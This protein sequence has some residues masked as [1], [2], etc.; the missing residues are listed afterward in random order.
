MQTEL[1]KMMNGHVVDMLILVN[2]GQKQELPVPECS[3]LSYMVANG[4]YYIGMR[5]DVGKPR[6]S[7]IWQ[8]EGSEKK[9][10]TLKM[11]QFQVYDKTIETVRSITS[12]AMTCMQIPQSSFFKKGRICFVTDSEAIKQLD[13]L[14]EAAD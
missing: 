3:N 14:A 11:L 10:I 6:V 13:M 8:I 2:Y 4:T 1:E 9:D 7:G 12:N 5:L